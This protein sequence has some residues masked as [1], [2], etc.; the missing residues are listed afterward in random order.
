[1]TDLS[2]PVPLCFLVLPLVFLFFQFFV[3]VLFSCIR[4]AD[5]DAEPI[6][7]YQRTFYASTAAFSL[8]AGVLL[9][10]LLFIY[11]P[12]LHMALKVIFIVIYYIVYLTICLYLPI[13]L[14]RMSPD[15]AY[16]ITRPVFL[17][18]RVIFL[19]ITFIFERIAAAFARLFGAKD[20]L[21][22]ND[23]TEEDIISMVNEGHEKG[24]LM[25]QEANMINNIF[26][27]DDK[28]AK[29]IMIHRSD[30]V[31]IDGN[32]SF[33]DALN[34]FRENTYSRLPV[35]LDDLDN[36]IGTVHM[37]EV[38][39]FSLEKTN[40]PK[41]IRDLDGIMR[42]PVV[43]P[44]TQGINKLFNQMQHT[45]SHLAIVKDEYGQTSGIV[46]MEDILEEIVGNIFDEHDE[47]QQDII[48]RGEG[49]LIMFG[50]TELSEVAECLSIEFN[51][52]EIETL[53]GFLIHSI[54]RIP[55]EHETFSVEYAGY[56]FSVLDVNEN[57]IQGVKVTGIPSQI[58]E[59]K[60]DK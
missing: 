45:K 17:L 34:L 33:K 35:Y 59:V 14:G 21:S 12:G 24:V 16:R 20:P 9:S 23:V 44:E 39:E 7:A 2:D 54:G 6:P 52:E 41:K 8:T 22:F 5:I 32:E 38:L 3:S 28:D 57:I 50:R 1:M 31:A 47:E 18:V 11:S 42:T 55:R 25:T 36:I 29:D 53:N 15:R 37:R 19:P 27:F 26:E 40:Y 48:D 60:G 43:V 49:V 30:V 4:H 56:R 13:F 46:S 58:L 51:T 10:A